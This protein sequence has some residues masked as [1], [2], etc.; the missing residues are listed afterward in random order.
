[1]N[2]SSLPCDDHGLRAI[3]CVQ[4]HHNDPDVTLHDGLGD[5]QLVRDLPV[6]LTVYKETK[7]FALPVAQA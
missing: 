6:R 2:Q 4:T 1:M 5:A 7:H 3:A